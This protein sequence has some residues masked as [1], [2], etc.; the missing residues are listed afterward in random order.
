MLIADTIA[1]PITASQVFDAAFPVEREVDAR[2][3]SIHVIPQG[4]EP[5]WIILGDPR[6]ALPVLR[7]WLPYNPG[8][9]ARWK[10]VVLAAAAGMLARLPGVVNIGA[11]IDFSYW[12]R[13]SN[14][15]ENGTA[16]IHVGNRSHTRKAI[17]FFPGEGRR[18]QV[19]AKVPLVPAAAGAILNE[20][21][22]LE[23]L[24]AL[25]H[26]PR[27]LFLDFDRGVA[28]QSWLE[29]KPVSRIF[30]PAH[31]ELLSSLAI[32][33]AV[34]C[35]SD[36]RPEIAAQLDSIDLPF[37]RTLLRRGLEM[38]ES[39]Q[40]LPG[41]LEHRDFAPWNL[42]RFGDGNLGLLD[43]EWAVPNGLPWQDV[44]RY[45]YIQDALFHGSG[46]VYESMSAN[47]LLKEYCAR[48]A[49]PIQTFPAL[50]MHYLLRVL[51][52][53]WQAGNMDLA[54]YSFRQ[55]KANIESRGNPRL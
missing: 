45:F 16:V 24:H 23:R 15:I 27:V 12:R 7:S 42:K 3:I 38:L 53:D 35:V 10:V 48:F 37:D 17:V 55:I 44:C 1:Q 30:T 54:K 18:V 11:R 43:W 36:F 6:K 20:A 39:D 13:I 50:T 19:V 52:M 2:E 8:A 33:G 47:P 41:F 34:T 51:L 25:K 32:P 4:A 31:I 40:P 9:R 14:L 49:I 5:R 22:T 29:G 26:L 21:A 46:D 28:A